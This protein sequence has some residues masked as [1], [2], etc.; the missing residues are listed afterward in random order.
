M[1]GRPPNYPPRPRGR[2]VLRRSGFDDC[3]AA[4]TELDHARALLALADGDT[5]LAVQIGDLLHACKNGIA[6]PDRDT[7]AARVRAGVPAT[8]PTTTGEYLTGWLAGRRGLSP[9][10]IR[11][12]SDHLG[13]I[14]LHA[15]RASHIQ[16]MFIALDTRTGHASNDP[17]VHARFRGIRPM[18]AS[19]LQRLYATLRV[20]LNDT[21][22]RTRLIPTNPAL[23][24]ELETGARPKARVWTPKAIEHRQ[25]TGQRPSPVMVWR[26]E[27]A[28]Q[29][30][31]YA[32]KH[33]AVLYPASSAGPPPNLLRSAPTA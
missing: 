31:D 4:R 33:D 27:Q 12:Y 8:I 7:V 28:G 2:R 25:A 24:I 32:Q 14:P 3:D 9:K 26:P 19:S 13:D 1:T 5:G 18:G 11:G 17:A 6:L 21:V 10:T 30:L 22:R 20:A 23:G 15:L 29:F 16:A